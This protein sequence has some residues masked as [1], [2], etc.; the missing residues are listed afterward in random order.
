VG[1]MALRSTQL[2]KNRRHAHY[3]R[4][5]RGLGPIEKRPSGALGALTTDDP[6][7]VTTAYVY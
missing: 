2:I 1:G 5:R 6:V 4:T 7:R 3:P